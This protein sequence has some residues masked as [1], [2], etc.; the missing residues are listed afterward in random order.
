MNR[1]RDL[2]SNTYSNN[3]YFFLI[4]YTLYFSFIRLILI[5]IL[6]FF[7]F[8]YTEYR[9]E[10]TWIFFSSSCRSAGPV[11]RPVFGPQSIER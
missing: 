9:I 2:K 6:T 10:F 4:R 7:L 3:T 5:I 1:E 11:F 8:C